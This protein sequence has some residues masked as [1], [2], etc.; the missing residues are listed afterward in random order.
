MLIE[1]TEFLTT[2]NFFL[3]KELHVVK[4][5]WSKTTI[6]PERNPFS[7]SLAPSLFL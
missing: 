1:V 2:E 7:I 3:F 4:Q 6:T 5:P